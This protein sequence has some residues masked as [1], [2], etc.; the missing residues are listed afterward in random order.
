M[1]CRS[2]QSLTD[3]TSAFAN[4]RSNLTSFVRERQLYG[5]QFSEVNCHLAEMRLLE[6]AVTTVSFGS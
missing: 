6:A 4:C 3:I 5:S 2:V 1:S